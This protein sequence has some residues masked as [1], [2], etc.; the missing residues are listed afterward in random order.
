MFDVLF[1]LQG[2]GPSVKLLYNTVP[3]K[4]QV[5]DEVLNR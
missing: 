1:V 5:D 4:K 2:L 3:Y